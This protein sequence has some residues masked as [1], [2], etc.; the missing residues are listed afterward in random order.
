MANLSSSLEDYHGRA[1]A[2]VSVPFN[3]ESQPGTPKSK[4]HQSLT[5]PPLTPPPSYFYN[6]NSTKRP[7]TKTKHSKSPLLHNIFP[8]LRSRKSSTPSSPASS[9]SPSN[10]RSSSTSSASSIT[11]YSVPSSPVS[12]PPRNH[13]ARDRTLPS[14]RVQLEID[15]GMLCPHEYGYGS[16]VSTTSGCYSYL[17]KV[18]LRQYQQ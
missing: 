7:K 18:L 17:I 11:Y 8:K 15:S 12:T 4:Y 16:S 10:S 1:S 5:L 2:L 13:C 9:S 6:T 14:P 3:W